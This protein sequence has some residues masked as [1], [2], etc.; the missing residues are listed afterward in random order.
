MAA[1]PPDTPYEKTTRLTPAWNPDASQYVRDTPEWI[2]RCLARVQALDPLLTEGEAETA[3]RELSLLERWRVMAPEAAA[4][5][6]YTPIKPRP[7]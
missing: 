1:D 2:A 4:E 6:L 7:G 5:Q 3:V